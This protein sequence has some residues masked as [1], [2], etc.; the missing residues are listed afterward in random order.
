[1]EKT[2]V[3]IL[4][5]FFLLIKGNIK[6]SLLSY[7]N[8]VAWIRPNQ[9]RTQYLKTLLNT[10]KKK[11]WIRILEFLISF[12]ILKME[13]AKSGTSAAQYKLLKLHLN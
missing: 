13:P 12:F 10:D 9:M 8:P 2:L 4:T 6:F 3:P 11:S 5:I 7:I 1:M